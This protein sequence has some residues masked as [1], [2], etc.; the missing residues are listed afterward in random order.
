MLL[1][2]P[3]SCKGCEVSAY[4]NNHRT[5][6]WTWYNCATVPRATWWH[7][8]RDLA[9]MCGRRWCEFV[10]FLVGMKILSGRRS[11]TWCGEVSLSL[12]WGAPLPEHGRRVNGGVGSSTRASWMTMGQVFLAT[13]MLGNGK[14]WGMQKINRQNML[15]LG[16]CW[17]HSP[18]PGHMFGIQMSHMPLV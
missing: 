9:W 11:K 17:G 6:T 5:C 8:G 16:V 15:S 7:N 18:N 10:L 1:F 12:W 14:V 13:I 2:G 4:D 3:A